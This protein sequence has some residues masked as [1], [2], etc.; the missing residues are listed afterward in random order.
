MTKLSIPDMS[1]GHC[2]A[3]IEGALAPLPG[4]EGI[5]FDPEAR[6]ADVEGSVPE[7]TLLSALD[8]IGF[9]AEVVR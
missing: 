9:P 1:C 8:S 7:R 5:R 4:F 2:R 3:S 6:T